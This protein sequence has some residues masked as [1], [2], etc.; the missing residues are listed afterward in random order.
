[1][2][3]TA[4]I[5]PSL[6]EGFGLPPLEAMSCGCPVLVSNRASLPEVCGGAALYFDPEDIDDMAGKIRQ[7]ATDTALRDEMK[8]MGIHQSEKFTW[9]KTVSQTVEVIQTLLR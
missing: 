8:V 5:F 6:Y 9:E 4:L 2:N 7:I 3:A 1:M